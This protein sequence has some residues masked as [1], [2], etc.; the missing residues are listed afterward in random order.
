GHCS[1]R[2]GSV[3]RARGLFRKTGQALAPVQLGGDIGEAQ[4]H[5][6][7]QHAQVKDKVGGFRCRRLGIA[8]QG[9]DDRLHRLL[10]QLLRDLGP[11]LG[12]QLGDIGRRGIGRAAGADGFLESGERI[13]HYHSV[14]PGGGAA[15]SLPIGR[16]LSVRMFLPYAPA[17]VRTAIPAAASAAWASAMLCWP[18]WKIDAARTALAWPCVTPATRWSSVPT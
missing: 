4:T 5:V 2:K 7:E 6:R 11:A 16:S 17:G 3:W 18:K 14:S 9:G 13:S 12:G 10:A 15:S 8:G 1:L